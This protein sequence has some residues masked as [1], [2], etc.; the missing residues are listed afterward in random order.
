[1][2]VGFNMANPRA[3]LTES[4]RRALGQVNVETDGIRRLVAACKKLKLKPESPVFKSDCLAHVGIP[5]LM[6]CIYVRDFL[7]TSRITKA[8]NAWEGHGWKMLAITN[9]QV[10][11]MTDEQLVATLKAALVELGKV[12]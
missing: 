8:R 6:V 5:K 3:G 11:R 4:V 2:L 10:D 7:E 9:P 12:K 1:M